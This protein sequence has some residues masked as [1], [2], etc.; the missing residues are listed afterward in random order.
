MP[1]TT[2]ILCD[3]CQA[4]KKDTNHWYTVTFRQQTAEVALLTL[5]PDG[6]PYAERDGLQQYYCG[7]YCILEAMNKW[8]DALTRYPSDASVDHQLNKEQAIDKEQQIELVR[9]VSARTIVLK[10]N[11]DPIQ[12]TARHKTD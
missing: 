10:R 8:M 7:R 6:R 2:Q 12:P 9:R 11:A 3:G 1:L 4:K 5:K